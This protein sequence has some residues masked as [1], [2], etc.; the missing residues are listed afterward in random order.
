MQCDKFKNDYNN[1]NIAQQDGSL[2]E[3]AI[4]GSKVEEVDYRD[5][6]ENKSQ[7]KTTSNNE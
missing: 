7:N 5:A 4:P 3:K 6:E 2:V 1:Q